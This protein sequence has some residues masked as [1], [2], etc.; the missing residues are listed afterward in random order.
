MMPEGHRTYVGCALILARN[1]TTISRN[2]LASGSLYAFKCVSRRLQK[3]DASA[4][5]L[6][7][8]CPSKRTPDSMLAPATLAVICQTGTVPA[9]LPFRVR[10]CVEVRCPRDTAFTLDLR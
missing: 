10:T 3:P 6:M 7:V 1:H 4:Y 8:D 9:V 5:R 2:A